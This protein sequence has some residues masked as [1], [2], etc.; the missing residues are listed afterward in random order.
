MSRPLRCLGKGI[1][2][3]GNPYRLRRLLGGSAD[4]GALG[5]NITLKSASSVRSVMRSSSPTD[6]SFLCVARFGW[7]TARCADL[8]TNQSAASGQRGFRLAGGIGW[9]RSFRSDPPCGILAPRPRTGDHRP[10]SFNFPHRIWRPGLYVRLWLEAVR[11]VAQESS[12]MCPTSS[13]ES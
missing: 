9:F 12:R 10:Q 2:V 8:F 7:T 1:S 13:S 6:R 4:A 3:R 11:T 5:G